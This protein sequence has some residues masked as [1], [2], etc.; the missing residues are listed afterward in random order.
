MPTPLE[1]LLDPVSL[2]VIALYA[3]LLLW[4]KAAPGRALPLPRSS[5]GPRGLEGPPYG[6]ISR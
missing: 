4:E 2:V 6:I 1:I 3:G 5:S